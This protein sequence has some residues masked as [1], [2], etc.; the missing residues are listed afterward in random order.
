MTELL[1]DV[2][3]H[4]QLTV[5]VPVLWVLGFALKKTPHI[6]D[7]LII[8]ILLAI[9]VAASGW[10]LGFDFNGIANGFICTGAAITTHQSIK[11]TFF[12]RV[13]DQDKSQIN[14]K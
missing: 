11:Q 12:A 6:P 3:I 5:L 13:E 7:W 4:N 1:N 8:W 10:R 2:T 14:K 9:G